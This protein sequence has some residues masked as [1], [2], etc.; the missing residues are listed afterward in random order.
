VPE[1]LAPPP[2]D[3]VRPLT[4]P[5]S[6]SVIMAVHNGAPTIGEAIASALTQ[7]PPPR[8]VVI[9]DDGSTDDLLG[10]LAPF[11]GAVDLVRKPQGGEAS[12]KNRAAAEAGGDF[13]VILDADD[14][15]LPGRLAALGALAMERPD[16][17]LLTT[18]AFM[19]AGGVRVA[20]CYERQTFET[21]DQRAGILRRNFIFGLAAIRRTRFAEVNGFSEDVRYT[22][23]WDCWIRLILGG[24]R[25]GLVCA[26]LA[27]YRLHESSMNADRLAIYRGRRTT[28]GRAM[29][30]SGLRDDERTLIRERIAHEDRRIAL[31]ELSVAL[32]ERRPGA[33]RIA[34]RVARRADISRTARVKAAAATLAP[35]LAGA[36]IRRRTARYWRAAGDLRLPRA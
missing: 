13:V 6:F 28:L 16:L 24:S 8:E 11:G 1:T 17:D 10:A 12:A 15:F 3:G 30:M 18:D 35:A 27:A 25:A 4:A 5:P 21:E 22:A 32:G 19:E 14:V 33:R 7:D 20:R 23:D 2:P 26:P 29:A 34:A 9:C 36:A 31:E